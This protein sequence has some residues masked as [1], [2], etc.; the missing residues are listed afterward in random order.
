MLSR[1]KVEP[2][3]IYKMYL[4]RSTCRSLKKLG[5]I[6]VRQEIRRTADPTIPIKMSFNKY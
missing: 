4:L 3:T 5:A 6:T 2:D 1:V